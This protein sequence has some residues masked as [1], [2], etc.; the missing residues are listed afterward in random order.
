[1]AH[2]KNVSP[3]GW[4]LGSYL[5]RFVELADPGRND[6]ERR[7]HSW[8]NT[9]VVRAKTIQEALVKVE[10]IGKKSCKP[11]RGGAKGVS[12]KWE[13]MGV[14]E[15][16]PIYEEIEDGA[17]I[18]WRERAPRTLRKLEGLVGTKESFLQ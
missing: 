8:E 6:P 7:F 12:V 2:D 3:V 18:A 4:Y 16:L 5:L 10:R 14:T 11:Y 15:M 17:E 13:Y 9:V 1:M